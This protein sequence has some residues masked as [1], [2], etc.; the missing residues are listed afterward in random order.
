MNSPDPK[1]EKTDDN[2]VHVLSYRPHPSMQLLPDDS[3]FYA[4]PGAKRHLES[5]KAN[6]MAA[7]QRKR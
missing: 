6:F 3:A 2:R 7:L 4:Q 1:T 5:V